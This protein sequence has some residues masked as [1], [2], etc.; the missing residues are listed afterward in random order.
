[1]TPQ[2]KTITISDVTP[3]KFNQLHREHAE[4]L[5]CPCSTPN[6][7]Y[8]AFVSHKIKFHPVCSSFFVSKRWI[9]ALYLSESSKFSVLDFRKTGHS[10]VNEIL[11][12]IKNR[13]EYI[14]VF[15]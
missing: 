12:G 14:I 1:M 9:E 4:T 3:E 7:P 5:S 10:Q 11:F 8:N 2:T 13:C 6:V 15:I